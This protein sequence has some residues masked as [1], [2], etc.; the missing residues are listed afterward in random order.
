MKLPEDDMFVV[1]RNF[2]RDEFG[3]LDPAIVPGYW[4][5]KI[6]G[7]VICYWPGNDVKYNK[8]LAKTSIRPDKSDEEEGGWMKWHVKMI[9]HKREYYIRCISII[10]I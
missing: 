7:E 2:A 10:S 6:D 9:G 4:L 8:A 5:E 1:V 3:E